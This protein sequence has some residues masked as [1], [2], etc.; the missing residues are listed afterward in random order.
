MLRKNFEW[1]IPIFEFPVSSDARLQFEAAATPATANA[2]AKRPPK[3]WPLHRRSQP[4]V[5]SH[6]EG[7]SPEQIESFG[8]TGEGGVGLEYD[9]AFGRFEWLLGGDAGEPAIMG[10]L[11]VAGKVEADEELNVGRGRFF[12][13][14]GFVGLRRGLGGGFL[15][16]R[17][18]FPCGPFP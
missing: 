17:L 16:R 14:L 3:R 11:F 8:G 10:E 5:T 6:C 18:P 12:R 2:R 1:P 15:L 7:K 4:L 9:F 13:A